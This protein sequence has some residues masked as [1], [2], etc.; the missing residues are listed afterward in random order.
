MFTVVYDDSEP[1]VFLL[2]PNLIAALFQASYL[3]VLHSELRSR[4]LNKFRSVKHVLNVHVSIATLLNNGKVG[5]LDLL[6][7]EWQLQCLLLENI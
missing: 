7:L 6:V 1:D 2:Q 4:V 5:G 3:Q